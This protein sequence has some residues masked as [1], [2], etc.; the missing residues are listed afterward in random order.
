M[1]PNLASSTGGSDIEGLGHFICTERGVIGVD[2][3]DRNAITDTRSLGIVH[4]GADLLVLS[5]E[6][7]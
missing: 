7:Y 4:F 5:F 1:F 2:V 6:F 3:V